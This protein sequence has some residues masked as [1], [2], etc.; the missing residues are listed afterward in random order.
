[1]HLPDLLTIQ[2]GVVSPNHLIYNSDAD[3][4]IVFVFSSGFQRVFPSDKRCCTQVARK[5]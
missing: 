1:M 5:R 3:W 4:L 2:M